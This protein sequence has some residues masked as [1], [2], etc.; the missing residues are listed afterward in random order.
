MINPVY[1]IKWRHGNEDEHEV[2]FNYQLLAQAIG[3]LLVRDIPIC[4]N[5]EFPFIEEVSL[6][7]YKKD[8]TK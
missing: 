1:R 7:L 5:D 2:S 3:E 8:D 6:V 4:F